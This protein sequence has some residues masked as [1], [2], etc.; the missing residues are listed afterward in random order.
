MDQQ[1]LV[2]TRGEEPAF[3]PGHVDES[4]QRIDYGLS[5]STMR[6]SPKS[7]GSLP[8]QQRHWWR[9]L[10]YALV[11]GVAVLILITLF[12]WLRR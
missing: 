1:K 11:S 7:Q 9:M 10:T 12:R 2:E 6:S 4:W 8:P 5:A 3:L